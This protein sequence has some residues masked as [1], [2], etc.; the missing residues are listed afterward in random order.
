MVGH[1]ADPVIVAIQD[2]SPQYGLVVTSQV[3]VMESC[4][5]TALLKLDT[6][7]YMCMYP[8]IKWKHSYYT[9]TGLYSEILC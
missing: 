7:M 1:C 4:V 2:T 3:I 6:F 9:H 8:G 5:V